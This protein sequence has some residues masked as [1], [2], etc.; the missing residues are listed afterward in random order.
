[1][2]VR[3]QERGVSVSVV[4]GRRDVKRVQME[5][6]ERAGRGGAEEEP[7]WKPRVPK[8]EGRWPS[9]PAA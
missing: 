8:M 4:N 5:E 3:D 9:L 6:R 7:P 2:G 1:M